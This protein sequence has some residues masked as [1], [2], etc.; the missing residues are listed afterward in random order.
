[1]KI[2][3]DLDGVLF[4]SEKLF[5]TYCEIYDIEELKRN[6]IE[7]NKKLMFQER[8]SW[9]KEEKE[10][11]FEKYLEEIMMSANFMPGARK[12]LGLLKK[13]GHEL[14][15]ITARGTGNPKSI[16]YT[17][18]IFRQ[19]NMKFFDKYCWASK[20]KAKVCIEEKVDLMIDDSPENCKKIA[21]NNINVIYLKDA[22]SYEI[23]DSKYLK[24]LYNWGEIYRYI[25]EG[26]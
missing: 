9:S 6:S 26:N 22:P 3:I 21:Q 11:F 13:E 25:K 20:N 1:M 24:T 8:Y 12:V 16:G 17:K 14:I 5:R 15:V 23:E 19:N 2:G 18:T 10:K 7:D 4:D